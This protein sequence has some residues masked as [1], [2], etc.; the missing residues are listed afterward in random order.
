MEPQRHGNDAD[1]DGLPSPTLAF[2]W[3]HLQEAARYW[4]RLNGEMRE[5]VDAAA[6]AGLPTFP[7]MY[8][9]R[10][11]HPASWPAD[12]PAGTRS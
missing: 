4:P 10:L 2:L 9:P 6:A 3:G 8:P 5:A 7:I 12:P 11:S 1:P